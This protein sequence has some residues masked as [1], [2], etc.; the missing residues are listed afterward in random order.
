VDGFLAETAEDADTAQVVQCLEDS[1]PWTAARREARD[2]APVEGRER[3]RGLLDDLARRSAARARSLHDQSEVAIR[4]CPWSRHLSLP[5]L[6]ERVRTVPGPPVEGP[7]SSPPAHP[8]P[9]YPPP[10]HPASEGDPDAAL[11]QQFVPGSF[12]RAR[13]SLPEGRDPALFQPLVPGSSERAL[14]QLSP[15]APVGP[16]SQDVPTAPRSPGRRRA[17]SNVVESPR[18]TMARSA[19]DR[20]GMRL[21]RTPGGPRVQGFADVLP[22]LPGPTSGRAGGRDGGA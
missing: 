17:A 15:S 19:W 22:S 1:H 20:L 8:P 12:E 18:S 4:I 14:E 9:V 2:P 7:S 6:G 16:P 3:P 13:S 21:R 5:P 11:F 10:A